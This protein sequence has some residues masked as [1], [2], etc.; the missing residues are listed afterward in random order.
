MKPRLVE[1]RARLSRLIYSLGAFTEDELLYRFRQEQQ[2]DIVIDGG[3][4]IR[5]YLRE[6]ASIGALTFEYDRY[7]VEGFHLD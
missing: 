7:S 3:Q 1:N 6:L 4:T 2:G 5:D